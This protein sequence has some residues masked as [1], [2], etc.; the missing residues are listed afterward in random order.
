M[1]PCATISSYPSRATR[2][3]CRSASRA[4]IPRLA[5][6]IANRYVENLISGNLQ[7]HFD[8]SSYSK[9]FLA[10]I[11]CELTKGRLEQSE[12]PLLDY[13]RSVGLVDPSAGG[14]DP[15]SM[16]NNAP[17]SLT[18]AN[19]IDLNQSL[20]TAKAARIQ[21]EGRWRAAQATPTMN[22]PEVLS[23][24]AIQQM[25][26]R[27]A[28]LQS[29]YE[30][31]LQRRKPDHPAVKQAAAAIRELDRQIG[32]LATGIRNSIRNQ[33]DIARRQESQTFRDR[34]AAQRCDPRRAAARHPLQHPQARSRHQPRALQRLLQ[35]FK[36]VS[37]QA[38]VTSNNISIIDRADLPLSADFAAPVPQS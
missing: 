7:R 6:K 32:S 24:P 36:E 19:L 31:E 16:S 23:N 26:Q 11:S 10:R 25:T 3:S 35:R 37:A 4:A 18:S 29:T 20:A 9:E 30:Q 33:Y 14:G 38:G 34:R 15:N 13:A 12:R 8:T 21:A 28:E 2:G 1:T 5:A 27:R 17:R 22:L